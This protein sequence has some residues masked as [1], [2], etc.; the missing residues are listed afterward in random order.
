MK[1]RIATVVAA[2][3]FS[4]TVPVALAQTTPTSDTA[5]TTTAPRGTEMGPGMMYGQAQ[6]QGPPPAQGLVQTHTQGGNGPGMTYSQ[7]QGSFGTGM[8]GGYGVGWMGGYAGIWVVILLVV[9]VGA[10][11]F[12]VMQKRK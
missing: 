3:A 4:V 2:V 9:V 11:A 6:G 7:G 8:M 5:N 1:R 10:V 12:I